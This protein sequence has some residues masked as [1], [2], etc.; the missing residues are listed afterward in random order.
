MSKMSSF[1]RDALHSLPPLHGLSQKLEE[2]V[3][4]TEEG[5]VEE[6]GDG[7]EL[8]LGLSLNGRFGVDPRRA[9]RKISRSSSIPDF[10]NPSSATGMVFG[11]PL[12]RTCSLPAET[13]E[14]CRKRREIQSLRRLEAKRKRI[15]K[16]NSCSIRDHGNSVMEEGT[17][18]I[19]LQ[20]RTLSQQG[21][22][23]SQGSGTGSSGISSDSDMQQQIQE[24]E[25]KSPAVQRP[26]LPKGSMPTNGHRSPAKGGA[27]MGKNVLEEMP[28]VF[29]KGSGPDGK[30]VEGFL[31]RYRKGDEVR[32]VCVCHGSFLSPA[33]F[34]RHAGGGDVTHP[35]RHI[36]VLPSSLL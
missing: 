2:E 23:G 7:V 19:H 21:S 35:M 24:S 8:S 27:G 26:P 15:Q 5:E 31:Y 14:D 12:V 13:E 22:V 11:P 32:I 10:V 33:E 17:N 16:Q 28:Y 34:V 36:V 3:G 30:R 29:T 9:E 18:G 20:P 1:L 25:S 6:A 4:E